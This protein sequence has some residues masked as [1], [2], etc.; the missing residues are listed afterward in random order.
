[1]GTNIWLFPMKSPQRR[2]GQSIVARNI[3][4]LACETEGVAL[5]E[6]EL[7]LPGFD[8]IEV[9]AREK[10]RCL[11]ISHCSSM[12]AVSLASDNVGIDC[13]AIGRCRNW[14]GIARQFFTAREADYI[15]SSSAED[16]ELAFLRHWVLKEAYIKAIRGSIFGDLNRLIIDARYRMSIVDADH[17]KTWQAWSLELSS[18]PI[19]VCTSA[20]GPLCISLVRKVSSNVAESVVQVQPTSMADEIKVCEVYGFSNLSA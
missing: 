16:R 2:R 7:A 4:R 9:F 13:E 17:L 15:E 19:A 11:S 10:K 3:L 20:S 14:Q 6:K 12:V 5:T 18:C 1:V 8:L